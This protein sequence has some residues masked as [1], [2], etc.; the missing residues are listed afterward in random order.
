MT[1]ENNI[2]ETI[3]NFIDGSLKSEEKSFVEN[4]IETNNEW[5]N[6]HRE[7]LEVHQLMIEGIEL[8]QPSMRF[9]Q[10]VMEEISRQFIV[11][12]TKNYLNKNIIRGIGLFFLI[13]IVGMLVYTFGQVDWSQPSGIDMS[14]L[15]IRKS[16]YNFFLNNSYLNVFIMVNILLGLMMLDMYLTR[17]KNAVK[18]SRF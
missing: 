1:N 9:T 3:W 8:E 14:K 13:S 5:R 15:S 17:K 4:M 16:E 2:D 18:H 11:P 10:N 12:A 7:L 6:K